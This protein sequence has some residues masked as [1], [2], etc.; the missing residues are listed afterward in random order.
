MNALVNT[1]YRK[2]DVKVL[3]TDVSGLIEPLS[4]YEREKLIQSG[5]HYSEMLPLEYEPT[6]EYMEI[7]EKELE[8]NSYT[9]A[10]AVA[11]L[12]EKLYKKK[13][14]DIVL[15]SLARAGT[16]IGILLKRYLR[17]AYQIEVPH[18]SISII[19][20]RGIDM[21]ALNFIVS[22]EALK[23]DMKKFQF[24]DGWIGK[25][26]IQRELNSAVDRF[27]CKKGILL[28]RNLAVLSDPRKY[29]SR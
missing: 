2:N 1:T 20:G 21:N 10:K 26:A 7:Y 16:P 14:K 19:R 12:G 27:Y 4:T 11:E 8:N 18:Y 5:T 22:A 17:M 15:I 23:N 25:G 13:G 24:V 29:S 28:D 9:T 6:T 3:L